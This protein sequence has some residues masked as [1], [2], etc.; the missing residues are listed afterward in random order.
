MFA[1]ELLPARHG[2]ALWIEY[3]DAEH[4]H[5]I[6]IDGGPSSTITRKAIE[7]LIADRIGAES[8]R[9]HDFELIVVTHIDADHI[10]GLLKLFENRSIVLRPRDVWFNGWDHL[11]SDL[12]GAKQ[13]ESLSAAIVR[14]RMPWNADFAGRAVQVEDTG[15]LPSLDLPGGMRIT[16]LSPT[17]QALAALRPV[18]KREVEK[19][20][21][22]P[23][24]AAADERAKQPDVL[25][26]KPLDPKA[27]A[28]EPFENDPSEANGS[29]IAFIAE[30]DGKSLLLTGDARADILSAGLRRHLQERNASRAQLSALKVPH[31]GSRNNLSLDLLSLLDCER[32]L[33]STNGDI[34]QHPDRVA[35]SRVITTHDG[36]G[37][38]FNYQ[39]QFTQPWESR[40]VK[41]KF[42]YSTRFPA[43]GNQW[44]R[45]EL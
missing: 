40:R 29:S 12:L 24:Q 31:H 23:G 3:G 13:G 36:A 6:L 34:Y 18:W 14:N 20:G 39:T 1:I 35:V 21:L 32:F 9:E 37:L 28:A 33:F 30:F 17:R 45:V 7:S 15:A 25:G 42:H 5:R 44:L 10:T 19:A 27:L 22:V 16:L 43:D 4:P 38:E 41:R 8:Q 11:P 2:D 26:E